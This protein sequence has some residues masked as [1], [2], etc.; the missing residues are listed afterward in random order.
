MFKTC[1]ACS[2]YQICTA[3]LYKVLGVLTTPYTPLFANNT[4]VLEIMINSCAYLSLQL[5]TFFQNILCSF[6]HT[7]SLKEHLTLWSIH[8]TQT[9]TLKLVNLGLGPCRCFISIKALMNKDSVLK[10]FV[11]SKVQLKTAFLLKVPSFRMPVMIL[12]MTDPKR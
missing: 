8:N 11:V 7:I 2:K 9:A 3:L 5:G 10:I 6:M 4:F 12:K 1:P